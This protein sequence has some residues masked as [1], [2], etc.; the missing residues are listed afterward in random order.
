LLGLILSAFAFNGYA[1]HIV[2]G[3]LYY[4]HMGGNQYKV[5]LKLF[6][7]CFNGQPD[8]GGLGDDEA[9]LEVKGYNNEL[10]YQFILGVPVVTYVPGNTNNPCMGSPSGIC[11]QQGV[12]TK[13]ITLPPRPTG[14]FLI[15]E[16]C[17]RNNTI[18][19]LVN[20]AS[21]GSTYKAYIPGPEL[22]LHNSSPRFAQYPSL[23]VCQGQAINFN[24]LANDPDGDSLVYSLASAYNGFSN[25]SLVPYK[26]PFS[27]NFPIA[28]N[29]PL[30]INSIS[31][32]LNGTPS[33]LGQW[34]ICVRV[35]E[36]RNG[37]LLDTHYRDFQYNVISCVLTIKPGVAEQIKKCEG[38]NIHFSNQSYSNFNMSYLWNFGDPNSITDTSTLKDPSY[39]FSDTGKHVVTLVINPGLPC[40]DSI[41]KTVYVYPKLDVQFQNPIGPQCLK[42]N[43]FNFSTLG[44]YD[45]NAQF[46]SYF[47]TAATP[48]VSSAA[49]TTVLYALPGTHLVK[50]YAKQYVCKDSLIDSIKIIDR[51]IPKIN[52]TA[53]TMCDPTTIELSNGSYSE[54][55]SAYLWTVS[56]GASYF[57]PEP[58]HVFSPA[59]NYSVTLTA[60]RGGVCPDTVVSPAYNLTVFPSPR[61]DFSVTPAETSIFEPEISVVNYASSD[62]INFLYDF[63]DGFTSTYMNEKHTYLKPGNFMLSQT[64]TNKYNCSD[65]KTKEI[66][67]Y[68]EFRFWVPNVFTPGEDGLNDVFK[69]IAIGVS[70]FK[71]ELFDRFGE[72]LFTSEDLNNGWDGRFKGQ[73]CKQ[74]V[75]VWKA[76]YT[77]EVSG[78]KE[79]QTGHVT[80]LNQEY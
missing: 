11:V 33:M 31:G 64:V 70:D 37:K 40:A 26:S 30:S 51:P 34:V 12:Y 52:N 46:T 32:F 13:I 65:V 60:I 20:P 9:L 29:P 54:Y 5:T 38:F 23:Y 50:R 18:L 80:L 47:G 3:E 62:V 27:G 74:D 59:G 72:K 49:N 63:N 39:T 21:Q 8:F 36:Y 17:C 68:P 48:S 43:Q 73:S 76:T 7:D 78:K 61:A 79:M 71:I 1:T 15:Y 75:Y 55:G 66:I 41:K 45:G 67:V 19:N 69:P 44:T 16:T 42:N 35:R 57:M 10:L 56:N 6:R 2:G 22:A 28:A 4:D 24:H 77:N 14:Y 58:K 53:L 25:D